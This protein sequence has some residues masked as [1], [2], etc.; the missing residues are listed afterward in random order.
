MKAYCLENGLGC[1]TDADLAFKAYQWAHKLELVYGETYGIQLI[2]RYGLKDFPSEIYAQRIREHQGIK[3]WKEVPFR[4]LEFLTHAALSDDE[5]PE[6]ADP[7]G[8]KSDGIK[9]DGVPSPTE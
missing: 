9:S 1:E 3:K 8:I 7:D 4:T 6:D 5:E 2:P